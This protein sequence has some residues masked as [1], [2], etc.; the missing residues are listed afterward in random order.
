M[1]GKTPPQL[2]RVYIVR[3]WNNLLISIHLRWRL[4]KGG[5]AKILTIGWELT[6]SATLFLQTSDLIFRISCLLEGRG[7]R[8]IQTSLRRYLKRK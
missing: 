6:I 3:Q 2:K 7:A 8:K 1:M 4:R 5:L